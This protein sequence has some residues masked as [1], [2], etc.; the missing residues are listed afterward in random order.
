MACPVLAFSPDGRLLAAGSVDGTVSLLNADSGEAKGALGRHG[1]P[2]GAAA[3]SADGRRLVTTGISL[4]PWGADADW[5]LWDLAMKKEP[6]T[7]PMGPSFVN[8]VAFPSARPVVVSARD[9]TLTVWD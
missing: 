3:F 7:T 1:V 9:R 8:A 6:S 4:N 5:K 2:A